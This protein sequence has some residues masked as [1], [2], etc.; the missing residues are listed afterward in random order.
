[1][2][3]TSRQSTTPSDVVFPAM[4]SSPWPAAGDPVPRRRRRGLAATALTAAAVAVIVSVL[5]TQALAPPQPEPIRVEAAP[6]PVAAVAEAVLPTVGRVDIGGPGVRGSGS[7]VIFR[8]DGH[9]ITNAHVVRGAT[10]I[11]VTLPDG[12][13]R[14]ARVVGADAASDLAVLEVDADG[15]PVPAFADGLPSVGETAIA[16]GSPFGLEGSVTAGVVS[17]LNRSIPTPGA[18]LVDLI[19]T[20]APINPGNSGGALVN[21][22]AEVIGINT[23]IL[24]A[25]ADLPGNIGIGFAIPIATA[26]PIAEQLVD[27]GFVEH[28]RL[29]VFGQDVDP[30]VAEAYGLDVTAGAVV[31]D[32]EPGSAADAADLRRG[33]IIVAVDGEDVASM[34]ELAARIRRQSP[35]DV[36]TLSVVRGADELQVR[37]ELGAAP[38]EP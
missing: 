28:A 16:I 21:A 26:L 36:V 25:A 10:Q 23:A 5:T 14:D 31:V 19:Q 30:A 34:S 15:L 18:P 38:V 7:A 4:P 33:D 12:Q 6:S 2:T 32:V 35:G 1:M 11:T 24:G 27:R 29:G 3:E 22:S 37:L 13:P 9:L 17:A 8:P 20:D